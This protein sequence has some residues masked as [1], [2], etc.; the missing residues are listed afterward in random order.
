MPSKE[1][2]VKGMV[3]R[4]SS[5]AMKGVATKQRR[6]ECASDMVQRSRY[7]VIKDA[8]NKSRKEEYV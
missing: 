7:A 6:K 8:P 1:E 5:A 3:L 4:S 2:Y